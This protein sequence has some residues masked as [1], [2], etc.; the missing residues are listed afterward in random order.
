MTLTRRPIRVLGVLLSSMVLLLAGACGGDDPEVA[1]PYLLTDL[2]GGTAPVLSEGLP[3]TSSPTGSASSAGP[4]GTTTPSPA[5]L[6]TSIAAAVG[7]YDSVHVSGGNDD[8]RPVLESDHHYGTDSD[9]DFD[10]TLTLVPGQPVDLRRLAGTLYVDGGAG[11]QVVDPDVLDAV[12]AAGLVP[13]LLAW[14]PLVDLRDVLLAADDLSEAGP[15]EIDGVPVTSYRFMLDTA[16]VPRPSMI[17]LGAAPATAAVTISLDADDLPVR[18]DLDLGDT[19]SRVGYA[20]WG[21]PV[22]LEV[23]DVA[24]GP[25]PR[26]AAR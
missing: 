12:P 21:T 22:D 7:G 11:W 15:D 6:V 2:E 26:R 10:A 14:N 20:D 16:A 19:L 1:G 13:A 25:V 24:R 3:T 9:N 4:A 18:L 23:P 8:P 5:A 17:L